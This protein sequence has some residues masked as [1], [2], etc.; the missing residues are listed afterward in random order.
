VSTSPHD[1]GRLGRAY[2]LIV[3]G[4]GCAGV[5]LALI[6]GID[7][8]TGISIFGLRLEGIPVAVVAAVAAGF[9]IAASTLSARGVRSILGG[10]GEIRALSVQVEALR[11]RH[12]LFRRRVEEL[13][14]EVKALE[15]RR[16]ALRRSSTAPAVVA[17]PD[18]DATG[19]SEP[20]KRSSGSGEG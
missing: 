17:V 8:S 3:L 20:R 13:E 14:G 16:D 18:V 15:R 10:V 5:T 9:A 2:K 11:I 12:S 19:G 1:S 4:I 6:L 7:G